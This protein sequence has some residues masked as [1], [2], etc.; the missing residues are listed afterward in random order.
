MAGK[1][2]KGLL[3][4]LQAIPDPGLCEQI[5]GVCRGGLNLFTQ[6]I[7]EHAQIFVLTSVVRSPNRA[8]QFSVAYRLV[9]MSGEIGEQI[10]FPVS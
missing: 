5:L 1:A 3:G 10:E 7:D 8:Q 2:I 9:S 6:P 4:Q